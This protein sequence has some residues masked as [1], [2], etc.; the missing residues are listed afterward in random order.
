LPMQPELIAV[1]LASDAGA[2]CAWAS[3]ASEIATR[4]RRSI[5]PENKKS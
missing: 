1:P 4:A 5:V 2:P 3:R